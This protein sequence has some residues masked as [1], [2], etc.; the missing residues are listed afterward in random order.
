MPRTGRGTA[1]ANRTDLNGPPKLPIQTAKG[2]PYGVAAEQKTAQQAIPMAPTQAPAPKM[3]AAPTPSAPQGAAPPAIG[4]PVGPGDR[5]AFARP[6]ERPTEPVTAGLPTGPGPGPQ[7]LNT[8]GDPLVRA[9]AVL[10]LLGDNADPETQALRSQ[11]Q[12]ALANR[13]LP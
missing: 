2:Q 3:S 6:T 8:Q 9:A 1:Y 4:M 5:G 13:S 11:V 12:A 10:N 7:V